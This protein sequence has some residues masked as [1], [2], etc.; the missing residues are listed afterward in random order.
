MS[1]AGIA[2]RGKGGGK[3]RFGPAHS[4]GAARL[5]QTGSISTRTPSISTSVDEWPIQV[6]RSPLAGG[7][8]YTPARCGTARVAAPAC[9]APGS[10]G[11]ATRSSGKST[12][13]PPRWAQGSDSAYH[14]AARSR[15]R[16]FLSEC[17]THVLGATFPQDSGELAYQSTIFSA[18]NT[19]ATRLPQKTGS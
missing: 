15:S 2:S 4:Y 5:S 9:V 8:S 11:S 6:M 19:M 3:N 12:R 14:R 18:T 16:P 17:R 1:I 10:S 13:Y 7:V